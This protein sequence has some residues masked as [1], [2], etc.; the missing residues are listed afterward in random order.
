MELGVELLILPLADIVSAPEP[1]AD[2]DPPCPG[3]MCKAV[4][5]KPKYPITCVGIRYDPNCRPY[6]GTYHLPEDDS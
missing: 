5:L 2:A 3:V 1:V 4:M 6:P